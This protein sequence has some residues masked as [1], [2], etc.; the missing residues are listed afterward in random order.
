MCRDSKH[1]PGVGSLTR[2]RGFPRTHG[3]LQ[4]RPSQH[5]VLLLQS[6]PVA[7]HCAVLEVVVLGASVVVTTVVAVVVVGTVVVLV[8]VATVVALVVVLRVVVLVVVMGGA[9]LTVLEQSS[10]PILHVVAHWEAMY[11]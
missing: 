6:A 8:V 11:L 7:V 2:Q 9:V 1:V 5:V 10:S 3:A 4:R